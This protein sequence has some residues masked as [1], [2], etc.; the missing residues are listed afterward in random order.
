MKWTDPVRIPIDAAKQ[1]DHFLPVVAADPTAAQR[2]LVYYYPV[3]RAAGLIARWSYVLKMAEIVGL[4]DGGWR[5][6]ALDGEHKAGPHGWRW[7]GDLRSETPGYCGAITRPYSTTNPLAQARGTNVVQH[8]RPVP[9]ARSDHPAR[10]FYD[11]EG[12]Y[13]RKP[14]IS[15]KRM[16]RSK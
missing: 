14:P 2:A 8:Q 6:N 7:Q 15:K 3:R 16:R 10:E 13:P 9:G 12:R 4:A 1:A 11:E 5:P